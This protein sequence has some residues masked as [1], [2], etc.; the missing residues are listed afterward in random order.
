MNRQDQERLLLEIVELNESHG[1]TMVGAEREIYEKRFAG[2]FLNIQGRRHGC[3]R[4]R[5]RSEPLPN[6]GAGSTS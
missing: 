4:S 6:H 2:R 1:T 5:E 3:A